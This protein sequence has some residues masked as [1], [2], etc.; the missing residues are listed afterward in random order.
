M[1]FLLFI[2]AYMSSRQNAYFSKVWWLFFVPSMLLWFMLA[3]YQLRPGQH[4]IALAWLML[5]ATRFSIF[6]NYLT[7]MKFLFSTVANGFVRYQKT[8][9]YGFTTVSI[10]LSALLWFKIAYIEQKGL[11]FYDGGRLSL[12]RYFGEDSDWIYANIYQN[13]TVK[14]WV[15]SRYIYGLFYAQNKLYSPDYVKYPKY[16]Q[17]ALIDEL[18]WHQPDYVFVVSEAIIDGPASGILK[19][20]IKQYPTAF[21]LVANSPNRFNFVTYKL[22]LAELSFKSN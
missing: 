22:N 14:L 12:S 10:T 9:A 3:A 15:P 11:S 18:L 6:S 17:A 5:V 1:L 7:R 8:L 4:L 21:E 20:T 16:T 2:F 13:P 19:K